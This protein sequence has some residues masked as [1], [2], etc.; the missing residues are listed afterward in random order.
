[1]K[2]ILCG[3]EAFPVDLA[4]QLIHTP[5]QI[6]NL[7]GPTETTIWSTRFELS[8]DRD[9]DVSIPIGEPLNNTSLVLQDKFGNLLPYGLAGELFIGG[10]GLANGYLNR[11]ALTAEKF[12]PDGYS[13]EPGARLYA[14]GDLAKYDDRENLVCLGRLDQQV[15]LRGFR[16]ELGEIEAVI[17]K[18]NSV[19]QAVVQVFEISASDTRLAAFVT[20]E[21]PA[22][23]AL[24]TL[25]NWLQTQL[26]G[27]MV[28]TEWV[29]LEAFPLT[30]NGKLDKKALPKPDRRQHLDYQPPKT[31]TE[32]VLE[33]MMSEVLN[34]DQVSREDDFFNLGGHSLLAT[35]LVTRIKQYYDINFPASTLFEKPTI[36][37]LGQHIDNLLW[38]THQHDTQQSPLNDDEEEFKL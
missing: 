15:K 24:Q 4:N 34:L 20:F 9:Y 37:Q 35:R 5:A 17:Q 16:I 22:E 1:M 19:K 6:W 12:V 23:A 2:K 30:P 27:Y 33:R 8:S 3:G 36:A 18:H 26:P 32:Q 21:H 28:P 14:T 7:Y 38:S 10:K 13:S 29:V 11:P 31:E 25:E